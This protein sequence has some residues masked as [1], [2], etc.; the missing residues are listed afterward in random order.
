MRYHATSF[1]WKYVA[2]S[3]K[4]IL[5]IKQAKYPRYAGV[6]HLRLN[7]KIISS[8]MIDTRNGMLYHLVDYNDLEG[9]FEGTPRIETIVDLST[10]F[11]IIGSD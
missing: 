5:T 2:V 7:P 10:P 8:L 6:Q 3:P 9:P 1:K 11:T 4:G